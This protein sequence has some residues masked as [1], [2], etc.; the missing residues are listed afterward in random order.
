M[1]NLLLN[2]VFFIPF[3]GIVKMWHGFSNQNN[4]L[5]FICALMSQHNARLGY[6]PSSFT[7]F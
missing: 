4:T 3:V 7:K 2:V 1:E 5:S 6:E